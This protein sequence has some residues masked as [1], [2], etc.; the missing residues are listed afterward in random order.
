[1]AAILRGEEDP[2]LPPRERVDVVQPALFTMGVALAAV[3]RSLGV[4]P[5]A[6]VGTS[7]GEVS[8]A[9]VS[10]ALGLEDG[11]RIVAERSRLLVALA[12]TGAMAAV[13]LPWTEVQDELA[14][15]H[16]Q[17]SLAVVN[18]SHST[19]VCGEP[20]AV[21][22]FATR[23][24]ARGTFCRRVDVDYAS[25]SAHM[26]A[27]LGELSE[28]L[29][30]VCPRQ[31]AIPFVS[32]VTGKEEAGTALAGAYWCR[33]LRE[34]VR[35]D[36]ALETLLGRGQDVLVEVSAHPVLS[37]PLTAAAGEAGVVVGSLTRQ[38]GGLSSLYRALGALHV[39]GHAV[40]WEALLGSSASGL[41]ELPT[42]AFQRKRFALAETATAD[43]GAA[44]LSSTD[45]P[46]LSASTVLADKGGFLFTGRLSPSEHPWLLEHR[47]YGT[48]VL[49]GT[50]ILEL[51]LAAG[52]RVGAPVVRE[53]TLDAPIV[54][55]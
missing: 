33:N 5:S 29:S 55:E 26:D 12:G 11:A 47:V 9:V 25:H 24:N 7:Q 53:L 46:L 42:Y 51:G 54:V 27:I 32:T 52:L 19:V 45:H 10:G 30:P 16:P 22:A 3:W 36:R 50:G 4:E 21:D 23:M 6:V 34:T 17:L 39:R 31:S 28:V 14:R 48:A 37:L 20:S 41:A 35:L 43:V 40:N 13:E 38:G 15:E 2:A 49:P 44:G 1:V 8:A 18:S